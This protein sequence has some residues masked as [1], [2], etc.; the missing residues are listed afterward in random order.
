M[1]RFLTLFL[2]LFSTVG[3]AADGPY[4]DQLRTQSPQTGRIIAE[5]GTIFNLA[6]R[7]RQEQIDISRGRA[8]GYEPFSAYGE[9]TTEEA[10]TNQPIWPNGDV[11]TSK[12]GEDLT[13]QSTS[14]DD[15]AGGTGVHVIEIHYLKQNLVDSAKEIT[16]DGTTSVPVD[17]PALRFIQCMHVVE[18]GDGDPGAVGDITVEDPSGEVY[19]LI[20]SGDLRCSSSFRMVPR[21]KKLFLDGVVASSA[22]GT[23]AARSEI[24]IVGTRIFD[25]QYVD[26]VALVPVASVGL[27][28][29]AVAFNIPTDKPYLEGDIVGCT[30]TTGKAAVIGCSW[31]GRL[32]P[33]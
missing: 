10:E 14:A 23:A 1:T 13:V 27:Q 4:S 20:A 18:W 16:L 17:D 8:H 24:R 31:F 15:T 26:P 19:S 30:H 12:Y 25:H 5:D 3:Y 29:S 6:D 33:M 2:L 11:S 22:S 28:D 9:R 21:G 7:L 32:E